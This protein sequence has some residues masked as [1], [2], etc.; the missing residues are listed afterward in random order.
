MYNAVDESAG[1]DPG[2]PAAPDMLVPPGDIVGESKMCTSTVM[3]SW[4]ADEETAKTALRLF[5][6]DSHGGIRLDVAAGGNW[7]VVDVAD[8]GIG[9]SPSATEVDLEQVAEDLG[10]FMVDHQ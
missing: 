5:S 8:V 4:F 6:P 1:C 2:A 10:G 7:A 3:V 9:A